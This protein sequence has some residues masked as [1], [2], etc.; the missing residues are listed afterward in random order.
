MFTNRPKV[1]YSLAEPGIEAR[2]PE[3]QISVVKH[4]AMH[5]HFILGNKQ[6]KPLHCLFMYRDKNQYLYLWRKARVLD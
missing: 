1:S 4:W 2:F 5:P 3:S 6:S